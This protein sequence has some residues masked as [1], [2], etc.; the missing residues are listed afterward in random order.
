MSF[1]EVLDKIGLT[2]YES[3]AFNFIILHGPVEAGEISRSGNI[4][5]GKIYETLNKLEKYGFIEIQ[6]SRPKRYFSR[7]INVAIEEYLAKKKEHL[8]EEMRNFEDLGNKLLIEYEQLHQ[9]K[10]TQKEEIF[11]RTAFGSEINDLYLSTLKEV[12]KSV[13]Y[14]MPHSIHD[15]N[16]ISLDKTKHSHQQKIDLSQERDIIN[17]FLSLDKKGISVKILYTGEY[18]CPF[19]KSL[20]SE[21]LDNKSSIEFRASKENI[22][23]PPLLLIDDAITM[24]DVIDP[25][26]N[27]TAIGLTKIWD[28]RLQQNLKDKIDILWRK[29]MDYKTVF[30]V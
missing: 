27:H 29:S 12:K 16:L 4:P 23:T 14:F 6:N 28:R 7:N 9:E 10:R 8:E 30:S 3:E 21:L 19:F 2:K 24:M 25:L 22:I 15:Q 5:Y 1:T 18:E 17:K 11:Y 20:F 26:D 13:L